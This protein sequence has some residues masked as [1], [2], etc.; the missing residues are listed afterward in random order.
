MDNRKRQLIG[1][2]IKMLLVVLI[3]FVF[4]RFFPEI[5]KHLA[6]FVK[7]HIEKP[8]GE[9]ASKQ[10]A[11]PQEAEAMPPGIT[12]AK[13]TKRAERTGTE[14]KGPTISAED[15]EKWLTMPKTEWLPLLQERTAK[16]PV[17]V[18]EEIAALMREFQEIK[19]TGIGHRHPSYLG[20]RDRIIQRSN[21]RFEGSES[22]PSGS[23]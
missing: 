7:E 10:A 18:Q 9:R 3:C 12:P 11:A 13:Q 6:S 1:I 5:G 15:I 17:P 14:P 4:V 16:L 19:A 20:R 22:N 23:Q 21:S 2:L 8:Q